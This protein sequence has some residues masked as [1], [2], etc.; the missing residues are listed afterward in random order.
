MIIIKSKRE[1][2][3]ISIACQKTRETLEYLEEFIKPGITT[4]KLDT[5]AEEYINKIGCIPALKNYEGYPSTI[6][7]SVNDTVVHGIPDDYI[8]QEGDIISLDLSVSYKGYYGDMAKTY[9]VGK[10]DEEKKYLIKHTEKSL[11][12][13]IERVKP[14]NRIGDISNAIEEYAKEHNL[15]IVREFV[16]HGVGIKIHED[17]NV[18]NYGEK[19]IGPL[20]KPGMIIAIEPMLNLQGEEIYM[21]EDDWT[22]KTQD[23]SPSAHFEHTVLVT[24]DG[25]NILTKR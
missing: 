5:L 1:I 8:L 18:P 20:L 6:C 4:K 7:A 14:N 11:Y 21:E 24:E 2:E 16:G 19:G 22:I 13:G 25:Y 12:E 9:P 3:F 10:I 17:P 15:G 23:G